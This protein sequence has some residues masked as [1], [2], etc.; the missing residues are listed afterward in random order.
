MV[1]METET[2]KVEIIICYTHTK[3]FQ[4]KMAYLPYKALYLGMYYGHL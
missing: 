1:S 3:K 2:A 4:E